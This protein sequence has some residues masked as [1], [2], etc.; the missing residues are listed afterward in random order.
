MATTKRVKRVMRAVETI[1]GDGTHFW[2]G[3]VTSYRVTLACGHTQRVSP[4]AG[5]NIRPTKAACHEC[6]AFA[7]QSESVDR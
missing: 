5:K 1:H 4:A 6:A 2:R 7:A 3:K